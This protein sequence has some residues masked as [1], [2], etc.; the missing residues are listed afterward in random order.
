MLL[1]Q[2]LNILCLIQFYIISLYIY[3]RYFT[4]KLQFILYILSLTPAL[5]PSPLIPPSTHPYNPAATFL[6]Y[7]GGFFP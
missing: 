1:V 7:W 6:G 3:F 5:S 2:Y 4:T